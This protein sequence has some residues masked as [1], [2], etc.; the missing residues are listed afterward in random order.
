[1]AQQRHE[2]I[3]R[4]VGLRGAARVVE[5]AD[6]LGVSDMTVRRDLGMLDELGLVV[7]VHGGATA[8]TYHVRDE[9]GFV[10][11]S[12]RN[13]DEK[14][15]IARAAA[16][17][18]VPGGTIGITA[19]TTTWRLAAELTAIA[20]LT[21]V[22]NSVRVADVFFAHPRT[23][24]TVILT[25]GVRTPSEALVG[26]ITVAALRTVHVDMLFAGI[27]G[28]SERTGFT[29]PNL[30]ES[31]TN[32][33]FVRA[34][35]QSVVVADHT[36]WD[37]TGLSSFAD[38]DEIDVLVTDEMITGEA[39]DVLAAG[40]EC[41]MIVPATVDGIELDQHRGDQHRIDPHQPP[42]SA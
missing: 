17:M 38:L 24:R 12:M 19:G 21:V 13:I 8:P 18:V 7:K 34:A 5:L 22:T 27:H 10:A 42:R 39:A 36:K 23:D 9:P 40:I 35:R 41:V 14:T 2:R 37:V 26:P 33:A 15:S 30:L 20:D 16:K 6:L 3:V 29:T 4:E 1:L 11:K 25:G 32:R 31:D 28:M